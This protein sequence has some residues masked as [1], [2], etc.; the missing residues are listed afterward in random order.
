MPIYTY[1]CK[2]CNKKFDMLVGVTLEKKE[3][4]CEKCNSTNIQR[5]L[6][7]FSVGGSNSSKSPSCPTGTCNL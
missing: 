7:S 3:L 4:K 5:I 1:I 6:S 2:D